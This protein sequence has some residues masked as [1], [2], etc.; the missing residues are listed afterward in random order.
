MVLTQAMLM[1]ITEVNKRGVVSSV[2]GSTAEVMVSCK[3]DECSGCKA[4]LLCST[5]KD[6]K[7]LRVAIPEG[8]AVGRGDEVELTGYLKGWLGG[9]MLLA[10]VPCLLVVGGLA[11]GYGLRL[12][13][14][15]TGLVGIGCVAAYYFALWAFRGK[16]DKRVE[17]RIKE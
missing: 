3:G 2:D 10:G 17:W 15:A 5:N 12:N 1:E 13:D 6:A 16:A 9:W 8:M 4:A 7:R 11:A 14:V